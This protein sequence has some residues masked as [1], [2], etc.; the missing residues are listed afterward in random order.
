MSVGGGYATILLTSGHAMRTRA[1]CDKL[2][3][4]METTAEVAT[5][6]PKVI[7]GTLVYERPV[8]WLVKSATPVDC[9]KMVANYDFERAAINLHRIP[10]W[11]TFGPGPFVVVWREGGTQA[12]VF[13]FSRVPTID[14]GN[15]SQAV[16]E[17]M[18]RRSDVWDPNFTRRRR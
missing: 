15:Q 18:A 14:F 2:V 12:G 4:S 9:G 13:D 10:G 6:K 5:P 3:S 8:Y 7:D 17:Y 11:Q 16:S 1:A